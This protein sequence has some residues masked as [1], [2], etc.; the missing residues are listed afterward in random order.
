[1]NGQESHTFG[2]C[3]YSAGVMRDLTFVEVDRGLSKR[4][5]ES[6]RRIP[7]IA[8]N[9]MTILKI[10]RAMGLMYFALS[11][12]LTLLSPVKAKASGNSSI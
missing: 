6:M 2:N 7:Y 8:V 3:L 9:M 1:M 12:D 11:L 10:Q 4:D 5:V